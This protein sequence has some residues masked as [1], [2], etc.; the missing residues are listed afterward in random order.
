MKHLTAATRSGG[1]GGRCLGMPSGTPTPT[2]HRAGT[3]PVEFPPQRFRRA[4]V[5]RIRGTCSEQPPPIFSSS[6][7]WGPRSRPG[8]RQ[9]VGLP[10]AL[11]SAPLPTGPPRSSRRS[12]QTGDRRRSYT[13]GP[14]T[15]AL[16]GCHRTDIFDSKLLPSIFMFVLVSYARKTY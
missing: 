9:T 7:L 11:D 6:R 5:L 10:R 8:P 3:R 4:P 13:T 14:G 16:E 2:E 15:S 1:L 12:P